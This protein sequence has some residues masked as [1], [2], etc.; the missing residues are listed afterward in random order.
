MRPYFQTH[1]IGVLLLVVVLCWLLMEFVELLR[2]NEWR[3]QRAGALRVSSTSSWI[4]AATVLVAANVWLY[5]APRVFPAAE[6]RPGAVAFAIGTLIFVAG[7]VIR[8]WSFTALG[9]YFSYNIRVSPDQSV[10]TA[11][12]YR[13]L[14]HPSYAGGLLIYVGIG[15]T[16]ANWVS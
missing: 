13:V 1:T 14:R 3:G 11:G 16:A 9:K 6:I 2:V 4:V 10:V 12:P 7:V 8:G 15:L 5:L